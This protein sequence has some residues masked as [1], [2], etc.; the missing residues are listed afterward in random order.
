MQQRSWILFLGTYL[1]RECGIATFTHALSRAI[2]ARFPR[3][4]KAKVLAMN[5]NGVNIYN[6]PKE[7]IMN[8][9]DNDISEYIEAAKK[10][11]KMNQIKAVCLQ[12]EFGIFGGEYG[13]YLITFLELLKKPVIVTFHS[14]LPDPD[15]IMKKVVQAIGDKCSGIVVMTKTGEEILKKDYGLK[16]EIRV[17]PHGIPDIEFVSPE[18]EKNKHN[19]KDR[20]VLLS[21]GY[22]SPSKGYE[23]V[24]ES[25]PKVVEKFP[26]LLYLIV[27]ETHPLVRKNDGEQYRNLLEEKVKKLDLQKNVKFYN[28]YTTLEEKISYFKACDVYISSGLSPTQIT[29]GPLIEAMGAGRPIISTSYL[30]AK[31]SVKKEIGRLVGFRKKDEFEKAIKEVLSLSDAQRKEMGRVAYAETR[32]AVWQNVALAYIDFF[33]DKINLTEKYS[34][35]LPK[36]KLNH[37]IKITD[38]FGIVQ[39]SKNTNPDKSSGYTADDNATAL[40]FCCE[41]Y[42][43]KKSE[44]ILRLAKTYLNFLKFVQREDGTFINLIDEYKNIVDTPWSKDAQGRAIWSLGVLCNSNEMPLEMRVDAEEMLVRAL[45]KNK[46][47]D[48]PRAISF[49]IIGL[50]E[51][52]NSKKE[53]Q[54]YDEI[55]C[56]TQKLIDAYKSTACEEWRWFEE[57]LT[58]S[59]G[60]IPEALFKAYDVIKENEYLEIAV[61]SIEFLI[62]TSF[63]D[64]K[65]CPVGHDGWFIRN[66]KKA[67]FDQQPVEVSSMIQALI[68]AYKT[69]NNEKYL[70][71]AY[72]A[73]DWY[74]GNN[75]I[76]CSVYDEI[77]GGCH[78]GLGSAT[79]NLNEGA[80]STVSYLLS[81]IALQNLRNEKYGT[82]KQLIKSSAENKNSES[83]K[84]LSVKEL[85]P[86]I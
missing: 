71:Y 70:E 62:E 46:E 49:S 10:I 57:Y 15:P 85:L 55:K 51:F 22:L 21:Y 25:L 81:R 60:K 23:Y 7:V 37:L 45:K 34:K 27:G 33:N 82:K 50:A 29:S 66:G 59:N 69:T 75:K 76:G 84:T 58:Y 48:S 67:H 12:H 77:T 11:N 2:E 30:H 63:E 56:L 17:I 72:I 3:K 73:F 54:I 43:H 41:Y 86:Q 64:F 83:K 1:P 52:Y 36:L 26:N 9:N 14:V 39:F 20:L 18:V 74:L 61:K 35:N 68:A 31:D 24:I 6:Y 16:C 28:K 80:E 40:V 53:E 47:I 4:L 32:K 8:I 5:R 19:L 44:T 38:D 65:F 79:V 78:D 13:S 42:K